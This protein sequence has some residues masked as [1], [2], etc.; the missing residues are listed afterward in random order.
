MKVIDVSEYQGEASFEFLKSSGIDGV[1]LRSIKRNKT[2]DKHF[3]HF[4]EQARNYNIAIKGIYM[5]LYSTPENYT[6]YCDKLI[7]V[8]RENNLKCPVI[9]DIENVEIFYN[10]SAKLCEEYIKSKLGCEVYYYTYLSMYSRYAS[11]IP[12]DAIVWIARYP[13]TK[14]ITTNYQPDI[15]YKPVTYENHT[16]IGWQYSSR[17][18][19]LGFSGMVDISEWYEEGTAEG[20]ENPFNEPTAHY[21]LTDNYMRGE[22]VGWIQFHLFRLGFLGSADAIDCIFGEVTAEAV[23]EAQR[24]FGFYDHGVVESETRYL[25]KMN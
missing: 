4:L 13:S 24:H 3:K 23:K 15:S 22:G 5:Y 14:T 10:G 16:L 6:E 19:I 21:W 12:E 11:Y 20:M 1:I 9:L 18:T 2:L 8:Y 17:C 25:L 7:E